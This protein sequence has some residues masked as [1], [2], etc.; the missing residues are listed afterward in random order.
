[1][2][3]TPLNYSKQVYEETV[4]HMLTNEK[5]RDTYMFYGFMLAQCKPIMD[6]TMEAP[7][8]VNFMYDHFNIYINPD[9]FG[10]FP[11]IERLGVLKHE[12]LHILNNHIGRKEDRD[13]QAF[14]IAADCAINQL[15]DR[16]HLPKGCI[17]P[18]NFPTKQKKVEPMLTSEQYY[19][20]FDQDKSDQ[21]GTQTLDDHGK[22]SESE[23][24]G[25]LQKDL[26]KD[27][28]DKSVEH[29]Q[30]NRGETPSDL[31]KYIAL[32][33]RTNEVDWR[34]VLR[35]VVGNRKVNNR[36]TIMRS[37]RRFPKRE[38]LRGKTK[39][40]MFDL[41]FVGD[42]SG[43]MSDTAITEVLGEA[44]NIC[45]LTKTPIWYVPVDSQAHTPFQVKDSQR[46]FNRSAC[47]GTY[48][49]PALE[50]AAEHRIKYNAIVVMTDGYLS[51]DDVQAFEATG[52]RVI[53]LIES[54]GTIMDQMNSGLMQAF[55]LKPHKS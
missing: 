7:A 49:S 31:S 38:D 11:L 52:K 43:S 41:L 42:E 30:K 14:N 21:Q 55:K 28:I 9:A 10:E 50:M 32:H 46:S 54:N 26:T 13:H 4:T 37:D 51:P 15:I 35:R 12:M 44:L 8:A 23:G 3:D 16:N 5:Y 18:D 27:M 48:L 29:T 53:W 22:W 24:D 40:R 39:D 25:D 33:F 17:F 19:E 6:P 20:L 47:G 45:K 34:A 1:M 2:S 36:R